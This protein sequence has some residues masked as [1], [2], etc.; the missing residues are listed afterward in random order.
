MFCLDLEGRFQS[1]QKRSEYSCHGARRG[2]VGSWMVREGGVP[3][4]I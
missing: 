2:H 3:G 1:S 4:R